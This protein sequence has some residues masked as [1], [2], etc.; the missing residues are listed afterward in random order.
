VRKRLKDVS[1]EVDE[2]TEATQE[3]MINHTIARNHMSKV[4]EFDQRLGLPLLLLIHH[5][6]RT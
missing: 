5:Q 2:G 1:D 3:V 4:N 6:N